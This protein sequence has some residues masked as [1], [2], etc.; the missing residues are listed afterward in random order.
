M[1]LRG[2]IIQP[3]VSVRAGA[4]SGSVEVICYFEE[5]AEGTVVT[6]E[7]VCVGITVSDMTDWNCSRSWKGKQKA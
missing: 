7:C 5:K 1:K 4:L 6:D 2:L 3:C